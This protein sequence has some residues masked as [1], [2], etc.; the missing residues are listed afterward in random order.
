MLVRSRADA[1]TG[2]IATSFGRFEILLDVDGPLSTGSLLN[3]KRP[4]AIDSSSDT[5]TL[6]SVDE[7]SNWIV[8]NWMMGLNFLIR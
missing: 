2:G 4:S 8:S 6:D 7:L 3:F 5:S 1:I